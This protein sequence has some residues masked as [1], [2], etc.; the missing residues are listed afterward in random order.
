MLTTEEQ[1]RLKLATRDEIAKRGFRVSP[2]ALS[3][4]NSHLVS[5][6]YAVTFHESGDVTFL[7]ESLG[8]ALE[9]LSKEPATS[10]YFDTNEPA[11]AGAR[12]AASGS[13]DHDVARAKS[14][15]RL[16]DA[17]W[18]SLSQVDKWQRVEEARGAPKNAGSEQWRTQPQKVPSL[19][20]TPQE[21]EKLGPMEKIEAANRAAFKEQE[22]AKG[23]A[24]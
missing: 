10:L 2:N 15:G 6:G 7:G 8:D 23:G 21:A 1:L 22:R 13:E 16:T 24:Q 12:Q 11:T 5:K 19:G 14:L 20:V 17:E 9:R 18:N 3:A 4:L